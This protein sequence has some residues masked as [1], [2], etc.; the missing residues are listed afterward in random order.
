MNQTEAESTRRKLREFYD[1]LKDGDQKKASKKIQK[2]VDECTKETQRCFY[3]IGI[4]HFNFHNNNTQKG[5]EILQEIAS[6]ILTDPTL[7]N[8]YLIEDFSHASEMWGQQELGIQLFEHMARQNPKDFN[9]QV[10]LLKAYV[11]NNMF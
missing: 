9:T 5:T 11:G 10:L 6:K 4:A 8:E 2:L 7:L 1:M 3:L